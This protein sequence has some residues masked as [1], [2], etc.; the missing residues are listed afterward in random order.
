MMEKYFDAFFYYANWGTHWFML[1]LPKKLVDV[2]ACMQ[3]AADDHLDVWTKGD[4]VVLDFQSEDESGEWYD[5]EEEPGLASLVSLRADLS[6]G[7]L[8][9]LYLGWLAAAQ[10][11]ALGADDVEPPVPAGL[12]RLSASL[13]GLADFLRIDDKLL[14]TAATAGPAEAASKPPKKELARWIAKLPVE[15]KNKMLL[16]FIEENDSRLSLNL[17]RRFES[18]GKRS[19]CKSIEKDQPRRTVGELLNAAGLGDD[20]EA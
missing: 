4:F 19:G 14:K 11:G 10:N 13:T 9:S 2:K 6:R 16:Q 3:Y 7:D 20:E 5:D 8:R 17:L 18:R 15:E 12:Q 1:R